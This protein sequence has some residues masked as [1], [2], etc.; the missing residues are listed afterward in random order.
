MF[1]NHQDDAVDAAPEVHKV[2]F[3]NDAVRILDVVVP[4]KYK[5]ASH[6]HPKN[7][8]YVLAAGKLR[9]TLPDGTVKE[10]ELSAGQVTQ[11]EGFHIVE[12]VGDTEVRVLQVEFKSSV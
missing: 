9:F 10:A 5:S 7:I 6:W 4:L 11:G 8:G 2:V 3:E 1:L 12:N